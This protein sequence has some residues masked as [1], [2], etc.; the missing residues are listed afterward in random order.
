MAA[1]FLDRPGDTVDTSCT[2]A[3]VPRFLLPDGSW[4]R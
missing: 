2:A 4:S 3:L 1:A